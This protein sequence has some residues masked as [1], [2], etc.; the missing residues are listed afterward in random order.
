MYALSSKYSLIRGSSPSSPSHTSKYFGFGRILLSA[1]KKQT[2]ITLVE[3]KQNVRS[4]LTLT[5]NLWL[6][7]S[8]KARRT[9]MLM[10]GMLRLRPF[11]GCEIRSENIF[12]VRKECFT[13][14]GLEIGCSTYIE[15]IVVSKYM[16]SV[17]LVRR[18][19]SGNYSKD[20]LDIYAKLYRR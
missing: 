20:D 4:S 16:Y 5:P 11:Y 3:S 15:L 18:F 13:A 9:E 10:I 17:S 19:R 6:E 12:D 7:S 8:P 14:T 1:A 2:Q